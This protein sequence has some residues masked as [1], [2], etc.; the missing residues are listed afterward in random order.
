MIDRI[1]THTADGLARLLE[2]Y[3]DKPKLAD[4]LTAMI[5]QW[6]A[7]ENG[8]YSLYGRLDIPAS[9]GEQLDGIGQIVNEPRADMTDADYRRFLYFRIGRNTSQSHMEKLIDMFKLL[10]GGDVVQGINLGNGSVMLLTDGTID[11]GAV[12]DMYLNMEYITAGGVRVDYLVT[13]DDDEAFAFDGPN[14][15]ALSL[16]FAGIATPTI[17]GIFATLN[18]RMIPF[19]FDGSDL[20]TAG[21]GSVQDSES[22]GVFI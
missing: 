10:T 7:A 1:T 8:T 18:R 19:A 22:G 13:H 12:L 17:G 4:I 20:S 6:Q 16:G 3:K 2:Q 9:E 21:L 11:L 14:A 15:N 5:D